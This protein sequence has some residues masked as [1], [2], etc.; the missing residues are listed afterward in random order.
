MIIVNRKDDKVIQRS[1]ELTITD[2]NGK[3]LLDEPET[4]KVSLSP[5][6][7]GTIQSDIQDSFL[8]LYPDYTGITF[9]TLPVQSDFD[10][11]AV[12]IS[13]ISR[14]Q[15]GSNPNHCAILP[16]N[17]NTNAYGVLITDTITT[18]SKDKFLVYWKVAT[19]SYG[20]EQSIN[21]NVPSTMTYQILDPSD[22]QV[23]ISNDDG[24][25][26]TEAN[27]LTPVSFPSASTTL[28]LAFVNNSLNKIHLLGYAI[29]Y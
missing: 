21:A 24:V 25:S 15:L 13:S 14:C 9:K 17:E 29:L 19:V 8:A 22:I 4:T 7:I 11:S 16:K 10:A 28:R 1:S 5:N 20:Q 27:Y 26:Y 3:Y 18:T 23:Y 12:F 6:D 2:M